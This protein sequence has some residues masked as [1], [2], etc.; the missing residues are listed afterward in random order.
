MQMLTF[1][2]LFLSTYQII[3]M[4]TN[5]FLIPNPI[6]NKTTHYSFFFMNF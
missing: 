5:F 1:Q 6:L 4:A 2:F 3:N